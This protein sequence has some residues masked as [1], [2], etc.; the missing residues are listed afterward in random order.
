MTSKRYSAIDRAVAV[1]DADADAAAA[2]AA[3]AACDDSRY[4]CPRICRR[5]GSSRIAWNEW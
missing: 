4:T 2:A 3:V 5:R 1:A